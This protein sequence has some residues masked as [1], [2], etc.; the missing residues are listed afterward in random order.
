[1]MKVR[2]VIEG[3]Y[4]PEVDPD[5]PESYDRLMESLAGWD[6]ISEQNC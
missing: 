4:D 6:I 5:D 1:M 2:L 3:E